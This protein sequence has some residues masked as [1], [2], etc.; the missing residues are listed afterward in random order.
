MPK[1]QITLPDGS[2]NTHELGE[3]VITVGRVS[4]NTLEID[5]ASVSSHHAELTLQ[6]TDYVLK[7]IG[8]TNGT[9]LNGSPIA[10]NEEHRLQNGDEIV[11]GNIV[12]S[13]SSDAPASA[14]TMPMEDEPAVAVAS[15]TSVPPADFTNASPFSTKKRKAD[16]GAKGAMIFAIVSLLIFAG[17]VA[18]IFTLRAPN[19]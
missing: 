5:D 14:R 19:L 2:E 13:Y 3:D 10:A 7:D 4:D 1:L 16:P 9:R 17:A 6:G 8:S 15:A 12:A 18:S 11:F